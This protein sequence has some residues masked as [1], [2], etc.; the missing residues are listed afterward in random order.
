M[1]LNISPQLETRLVEMARQEG[2]GPGALVEK[3]LTEYRPA[4]ESPEQQPARVRALL[5]KSQEETRT[6]FPPPIPTR[7]GETQTQ[8]LFRQWSE[9]DALMM[10]C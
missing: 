8:A 3:L 2:V 7:P 10:H 5:A 4:K 1:T 6:V 9:E